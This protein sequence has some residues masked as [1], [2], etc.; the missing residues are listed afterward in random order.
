MSLFELKFSRHQLSATEYIN[1]NSLVTTLNS[2]RLLKYS[3]K[4]DI[5]NTR[6]KPIPLKVNVMEHY[7]NMGV[8][9]LPIIVTDDDYCLDGRHRV[10][11]RKLIN[12]T[13][14]P[15]YICLLYT[16]DAAD[17]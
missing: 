13:I 7:T 9:N 4:Y 3:E 12:D 15:A 10:A 2:L 8:G 11:Y 1:I 5:I 17:E 6:C 16:S 14:C